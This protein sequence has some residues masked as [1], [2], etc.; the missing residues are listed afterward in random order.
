MS[1]VFI[2]PGMV[3]RDAKD[4]LARYAVRSGTITAADLDALDRSDKHEP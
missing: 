2:I 1:G 4:S 3:G